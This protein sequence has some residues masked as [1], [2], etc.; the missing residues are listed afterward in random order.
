MEETTSI[1]L[2]LAVRALAAMVCERANALPPRYSLAIAL[3]EG[4]RFVIRPSDGVR[5]GWD[6]QADLRIITT[7]RS[8]EAFLRGRLRDSEPGALFVWTGDASSME[9]LASL[10]APATDVLAVRCRAR[11]E[12]K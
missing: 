4:G 1:P 6:G 3:R 9:A 2:P 11:P 5:K 10:F 7:A 8:L 12:V